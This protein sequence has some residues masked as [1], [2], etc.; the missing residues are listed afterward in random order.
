MIR[1]H[2]IALLLPLALLSVFTPGPRAQAQEALAAQET[3]DVQPALTALI[4]PVNRHKLTSKIAATGSVVAWREMPIG[5]EANG[6]AVTAINVDEGDRVAKGDILAKLDDSVLQTEIAQQNAA[7]EE[8]KATLANAQSDL[9]RAHRMTQGVLSQQTVEQRATAVATDAAKLAAAKALLAQYQAQARQ[10][11]IRSPT[12][13]VVAARSVTLGQVVQSGTEMFR[14]I[15]DG[16]LEVD[17]KVPEAD[18]SKIGQ[19]QAV[20]VVGPDGAHYAAKVRLVAQ[21]VDAPTRLGTVHVALAPDT[22]LKI[23]MFARVEIETGDKLALAVPQRALV[24]RDGKAG[25]FVLKS[26][27]KVAFAPIEAGAMNGDL[28]EVDSGLQQDARIVVDGA[29]LLNDGDT[30]NAQVAVAAGDQTP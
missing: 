14:L 30:I 13:A 2:D 6:L 18:L 9:D 7:I 22:P 8:A 4:A 29:G 20:T 24:W 23:G 3:P 12:D 26:G 10:T 19:G 21:V 25:V 1:L 16:R 27:N 28:V 17:A 15:R 11:V 5:S